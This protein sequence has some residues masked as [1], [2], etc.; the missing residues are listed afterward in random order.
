MIVLPLLIVALNH[1]ASLGAQETSFQGNEKNISE[2]STTGSLVNEGP[3]N[4][5]TILLSDEEFV[6]YTEAPTLL[7]D[8]TA[9][10][11]QLGVN[12]SSGGP[13]IGASLAPT[14]LTGPPSEIVASSTTEAPPPPTTT[15]TR[16]NPEENKNAPTEGMTEEAEEAE[17]EPLNGAGRANST[18]ENFAGDLAEEEPPFEVPQNISQYMDYIERLFHDLRH[19]IRDLFE[20]HLPQLIRQSQSVELSNSCSYDMLRMAFALRQFEPWALKM[21][22]SSGKLPEGIFEGSFTALGSYDQ[23]LGVVF[24]QGAGQ[25]QE[26]SSAANE[27]QVA[28][29]TRGKYCLVTVSPF[30]PPKPPMERVDRLFQEEAKRRNYTEDN[31]FS[32]LSPMFYYMKFRIGICIPSSCELSDLDS[33]SSSLSSN[34]R[35]NISIPDCRVELPGG[36]PL[37]SYQLV[38]GSIFATV[39][40]LV[41]GAT[42]YDWLRQ[43]SSQLKRQELR[44]LSQVG[45]DQLQQQQQQQQVVVFVPSQNE[46]E[47]EEEE[48][49]LGGEEKF[50]KRLE[51]N[52][53]W[54][55]FSLRTS[56]RLYFGNKN[57]EAPNCRANQAAPVMMIKCLDG[58]RV[59]S[60]CWVIVANSYLTL[61]PRATKR[62]TKTREI[63]KDFVFQIVAQASLAIETFFFLSGLL[64]SLSFLRKFSPATGGEI[65]PTSERNNERQNRSGSSKWLR[66]LQFYVHRYVRVTPATM[67]IIALSMF[68]YRFGD[69]PIWFE[70]T[71]RAHESC[72]VNWWRHLLHVANFIDTR[73]MCFIHYWFISADMQLFLV[74]PLLML[75]TLNHKRL[76]YGLM[77]LVGL[78]SIVSV[79]Y[80]TYSRNLPPTLLFY[81][82]DPESRREFGNTIMTKPLSHVLP[83]LVGMLVGQWLSDRM[84]EAGGK[85][86]IG[87][88]KVQAKSEN[89]RSE[90]SRG[91]S[92][93]DLHPSNKILA[94]ISLFVGLAEV[95][96]PYKW[97][98]S[99]LP[100]RLAGALYAALFRLA[101]SLVLAYVVISCA[102]RP[103]RRC[104]RRRRAD[105]ACE[106][107]AAKSL[108]RKEPQQEAH[109]YCFCG[110]GG[111][112]INKLLGLSAF[113]HLS[114]LSF[115]AYL[116][117]L[118]LM[119]LFVQQTR[120]LF[121]FS[122][123][124]VIHLALS[125]LVMTFLLAF[126]LVHVIEFPFITFE[127]L[128]F[129]QWL[130]RKDRPAAKVCPPLGQRRRSASAKTFSNLP[131][132]MRTS[133]SQ[134]KSYNVNVTDI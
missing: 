119:S 111:G 9:S 17:E 28:A 40:T 90:C 31:Q 21:I 133:G 82:S 126:V 60:L 128:L 29:P 93:F 39:L 89:E 22:D 23:C 52:W 112:L 19:Q 110:R 35:L 25:Q 130:R 34:L 48:E 4:N 88:S 113:T 16:V 77:G 30:M 14:Q 7:F 78:A 87:N 69:G 33:I 26:S 85:R 121:A 71:K 32:R 2:T 103:T 6:D 81:S 53:A 58:I 86:R 75:L 134:S 68:L 73:S 15:T 109:E 24:G 70:A 100:S 95:F 116:V 105:W 1:C 122:H 76:G 56:F 57:Q 59:I 79:F 102:H 92:L 131:A 123:T 49:E 129:G 125:Y 50:S 94:L 42:F 64:M 38:A 51:E 101:W 91:R 104:L 63:P 44:L 5:G 27:Q 107:C 36:Q 47:Q 124:L 98:N 80:T 45:I 83:Y 8:G 97:N 54:L 72:K 108:N 117:H 120:G 118:P 61:D 12:R 10:E 46:S 37:A 84:Q 114:K 55:A 11:A 115:V 99:H 3:A 13:E 20:P 106:Q 127:R 41:L 66:W 65:R 62:L 43:Q 67:L 18:R 96:L 74:A 132:I